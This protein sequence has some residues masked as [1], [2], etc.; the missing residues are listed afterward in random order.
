MKKIINTYFHTSMLSLNIELVSDTS[1]CTREMR[2]EKTVTA[3]VNA[4]V[5][6]TE[7][8]FPNEVRIFTMWQHMADAP[9]LIPSRSTR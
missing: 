5:S 2:V 8:H 1:G 7:L 6:D 4:G 9:Q 3:C